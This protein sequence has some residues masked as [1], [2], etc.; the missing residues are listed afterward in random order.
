MR[1]QVNHKAQMN[2][3]QA[4]GRAVGAKLALFIND[5]F[6]QFYK[7]GDMSVNNCWLYLVYMQGRATTWSNSH[8]YS[9]DRMV[10]FYENLGHKV[11]LIPIEPEPLE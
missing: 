10:A 7:R 4:Q 1:E 3:V 11:E 2:R 5:E 9:L 8:H 6:R